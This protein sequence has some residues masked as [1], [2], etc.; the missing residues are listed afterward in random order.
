MYIVHTKL[1]P[2]KF[3]RNSVYS[4]LD[5]FT[6]AGLNTYG[7]VE[8][9]RLRYKATLRI[10]TAVQTI[11]RANL[12]VASIQHTGTFGNTSLYFLYSC[13]TLKN[14]KKVSFSKV[15][16]FIHANCIVYNVYNM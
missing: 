2:G 4:N 10:G 15:G 5:K 3:G 6:K 1:G 14:I 7:D 16:E 11:L 12:R 8:I 9:G 13:W